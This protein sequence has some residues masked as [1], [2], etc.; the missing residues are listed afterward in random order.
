MSHEAAPSSALLNAV[1][2]VVLALLVALHWGL[3]RDPHARGLELFPN[4]AHAVPAEAFSA[5]AVL[6]GGMTLQPAAE[7][8]IARGWSPLHLSATPEDALRAGATLENPFSLDD[9]A[10]V[11]RGQAV[12]T[13]ACVLCH[14]ST[15]AGDGP[16]AQRGFPAPPSLLA[17]NARQMRDGQIFHIV[18]FGQGNM[19]GHAA[20]LDRA[21]RWLAALRV[22]VLQRD[23]E[24]EKGPEAE[25]A[26]SG[27]PAPRDAA[28]G[29][30]E[31]RDAEPGDAP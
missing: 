16:V 2:L 28:P 13:R 8:T 6:Q 20:Q 7:G 5:N 26:P 4:M 9:P 12:F 15:G 14:G 29:D 30:A 11:G 25:P 23:A 24:P 31:P 19:P 10:A 27:E 3:G 21:D 22:R 18:T 1:L 17:A